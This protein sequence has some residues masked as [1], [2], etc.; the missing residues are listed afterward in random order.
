MDVYLKIKPE[1]YA[2]IVVRRL[3]YGDAKEKNNL[4]FRLKEELKVQ[5]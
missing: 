4:L 3:E 5:N 1:I 2:P